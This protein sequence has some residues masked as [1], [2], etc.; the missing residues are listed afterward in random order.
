MGT[1]WLKTSIVGTRYNHLTEAVLTST[2]NLCIWRLGYKMFGGGFLR[3][4]GGFKS[5]C[6]VAAVSTRHAELDPL[7][8]KVNRPGCA[9]A[10]FYE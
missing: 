1:R 4:M 5:T 9:N 10:F 3:F 7:A 2:H 8:S 6:K